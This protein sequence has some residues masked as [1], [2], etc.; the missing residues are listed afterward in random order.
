MGLSKKAMHLLAVLFSDQSTINLP[1]AYA[2]EA[3]EIRNW[4]AALQNVKP[5][6]IEN[7]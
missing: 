6:E 1:I 7:V 4:I 5:E 2:A 3:I